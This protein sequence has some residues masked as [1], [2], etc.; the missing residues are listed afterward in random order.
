VEAIVRL[1]HATLDVYGPGFG[2]ALRL[3]G[4][5]RGLVTEPLDGQE[6][7]PEVADPDEVRIARPEPDV[8]ERSERLADL[9]RDRLARESLVHR[10]LRVD[11]SVR[12][13]VAFV[14]EKAA[15]R[16]REDLWLRERRRAGHG[17]GSNRANMNVLCQ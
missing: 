7:V 11:D 10:E 5:E 12:L 9:G 16:V 14:G 6:V 3:D 13:R 15:F 2:V 8:V 1:N 4:D 17:R